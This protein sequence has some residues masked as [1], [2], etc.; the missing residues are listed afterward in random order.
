M[1]NLL[2]VL[3]HGEIMKD[4]E[5]SFWVE[6][7]NSQTDYTKYR[8][9]DAREILGKFPSIEFIQP[10]IEIGSGLM[11]M[12][13]FFDTPYVS[14]DPLADIYPKVFPHRTN[15][16]LGSGEDLIFK[17]ES[18]STIICVNV[19]DHTKNP[20]KLL[21]EAN[22]VL[23]PNGTLYLQVQIEETLTP[24]NYHKMSEFDVYQSTN[25]YFKR[26]WE[27]LHGKRHYLILQKKGV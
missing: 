22:R 26:K 13:E 19:L 9:K 4:R 15:Y 17:D 7:F 1:Q 20:N 6:L 27:K 18:I 2:N 10:V 11:S 16:L 23:K 8:E 5:L 21:K 24:P 3:L 25:Q 12:L 14:I